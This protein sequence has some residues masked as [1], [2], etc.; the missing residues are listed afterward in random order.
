MGSGGKERRGG[1]VQKETRGDS[2]RNFKKF[3][4]CL[5]N[6]NVSNFKHKIVSRR[7]GGYK[8]ASRKHKQ[9]LKTGKI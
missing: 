7:N 6:S 2:K 4:M 8:E 5:K 9:I 3:L 1:W